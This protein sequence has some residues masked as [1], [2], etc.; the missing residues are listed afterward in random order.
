MRTCRAVAGG[1]EAHED[2]RAAG[3]PEALIAKNV[4]F[5][6]FE[7]ATTYRNRRRFTTTLHIVSCL[8]YGMFLFVLL[9]MIYIWIQHKAVAH[10]YTTLAHVLSRR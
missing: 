9:N 2:V 5:K 4:V 6:G 1:H 7:P 8:R 10:A 3:G